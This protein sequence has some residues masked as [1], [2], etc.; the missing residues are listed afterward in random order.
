M[1]GWGKYTKKTVKIH[2]WEITT[3]SMWMLIIS[4]FKNSDTDTH[5]YFLYKNGIILRSFILTL[6][7]SINYCDYFPTNISQCCLI[8]CNTLFNLPFY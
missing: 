8:Q 6:F 2:H 3:F 1:K 4:V 5:I 7:Q